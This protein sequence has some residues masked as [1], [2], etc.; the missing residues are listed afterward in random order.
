V[1]VH[2][3]EASGRS[4]PDRAVSTLAATARSAGRW[5]NWSAQLSASVV[6]RSFLS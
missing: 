2:H 3:S 1:T 5:T 4:T 6:D